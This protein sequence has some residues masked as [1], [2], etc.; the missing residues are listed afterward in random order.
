M[1]RICK[2][3]QGALQK[4]DI[5]T[6]QWTKEK[7]ARFLDLLAATANASASARDVGM[8]AWSAF[9]LRR[10]DPAFA[11]LWQAALETAYVVLE[12]TLLER[13]IGASMDD[14][15]N[16]IEPGASLSDAEQAAIA[17]TFDVTL[18]QELLKRRDGMAA[19]RKRPAPP[20]KVLTDEELAATL[21]RKLAMLRKRLDRKN[22]D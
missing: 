2:S 12:T 1:E 14:P 22:G 19:M 16:A 9:A 17:S 18:A 8:S 15:A 4:Q 21:D 11:A 3:S 10:R 5:R 6:R 20:L 7:R 13:A